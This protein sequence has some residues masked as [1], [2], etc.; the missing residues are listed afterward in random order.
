MGTQSTVQSTEQGKPVWSMAVCLSTRTQPQRACMRPALPPLPTDNRIPHH[1]RWRVILTLEGLTSSMSAAT[2]R[3]KDNREE[4]K[5]N[6]FSLRW[7]PTGNQ[8]E[9]G[10][11]WQPDN[12][13][14]QTTQLSHSQRQAAQQGLIWAKREQ[15]KGRNIWSVLEYFDISYHFLWSF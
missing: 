3:A 14:W 8:Q 12:Q 6:L 5:N 1:V 9:M 7:R 4:K 2:L 13:P 11:P 10:K 15:R